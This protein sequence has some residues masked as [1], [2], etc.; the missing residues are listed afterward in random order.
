MKKPLK[1]MKMGLSAGISLANSTNK[2]ALIAKM[3]TV[4]SISRLKRERPN[5]EW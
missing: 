5:D 1:P 2:I 3:F 4:H